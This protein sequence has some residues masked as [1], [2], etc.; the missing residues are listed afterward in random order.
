MSLGSG[1]PALLIRAPFL[2]LGGR[3]HVV[4]ITIR[5]CHCSM[6]STSSWRGRLVPF[7][8]WFE[9]PSKVGIYYKVL[10]LHASLLLA[11][12]FLLLL[13]AVNDFLGFIV[14]TQDHRH[15]AA[16]QNAYQ[17]VFLRQIWGKA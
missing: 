4:V 13:L 16:I 6:C 8:N 5:F 7:Y 14:F 15:T 2:P 10:D 3:D 1:F 9:P 12:L 11:P 17:I